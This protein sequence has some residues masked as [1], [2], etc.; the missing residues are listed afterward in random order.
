MTINSAPLDLNELDNFVCME[1][2]TTSHRIDLNPDLVFGLLSLLSDRIGFLPS[3]LSP[4]QDQDSIAFLH[5]EL[6]NNHWYV[7]HRDPEDR[8]WRAL[9]MVDAG[10]MQGRLSDICITEL[11]RAG[12][13]IDLDWEPKPVGQIEL[14]GSSDF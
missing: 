5:Y 4:D 3:T 7:T 14:R 8:Q 9:G 6:G 13:S 11:L 1:Q 2:M 10:E 12:A